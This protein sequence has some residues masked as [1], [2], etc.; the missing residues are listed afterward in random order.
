M[1]GLSWFTIGFT[2]M[3]VPFYYAGTPRSICLGYAIINHQFSGTPG[4]PT[5]VGSGP[6]AADR[7][8]VGRVAADREGGRG[9][10]R[11]WRWDRWGS[12]GDPWKM[13]YQKFHVFSWNHLSLVDTG[14]VFLGWSKLESKHVKTLAEDGGD[15]SICTPTWTH[16][17]ANGRGDAVMTVVENGSH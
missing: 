5:T 16:S 2:N 10:S 3:E 9:E 12:P 7:G 14:W 13:T 8:A 15:S 1:A 17:G 11:L 6:A 4:T